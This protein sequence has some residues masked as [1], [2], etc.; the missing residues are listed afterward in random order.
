MRDVGVLF[1]GEGELRNVLK[2]V[3]VGNFGFMWEKFATCRGLW[4]SSGRRCA[5]C[6]E[7]IKLFN[8]FDCGPMLR[9]ASARGVLAL[10][11]GPC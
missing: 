5:R 8:W 11:M 10:V 4:W 2:Y 3:Y 9:G 7:F 6:C 1:S